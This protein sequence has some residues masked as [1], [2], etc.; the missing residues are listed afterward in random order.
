MA[1]KFSRFVIPRTAFNDPRIFALRLR[2]RIGCLTEHLRKPL[3]TISIERPFPDVSMHI[4]QSPRIRFLLP[5]P[6]AFVTAVFHR[7]RIFIEKLG[8]VAER[9]TDLRPCP[10]RIVRPS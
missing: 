8:I 3:G 5:N 1:P 2:P 6:M 7:P 10:R 4:M 9:P